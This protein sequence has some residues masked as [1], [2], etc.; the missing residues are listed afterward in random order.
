M[1]LDN[2]PSRT[3]IGGASDGTSFPVYIM[4]SPNLFTRTFLRSFSLRYHI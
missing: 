1:T 2:P 4:P 3:C